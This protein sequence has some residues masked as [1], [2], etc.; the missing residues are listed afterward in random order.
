MQ[1]KK[2]KKTIYTSNEGTSNDRRGGWGSNKNEEQVEGWE[3]I[4]RAF[5]RAPSLRA[6]KNFCPEV[7]RPTGDLGPGS[8]HGTVDRT[9]QA[10]TGFQWGPWEAPCLKMFFALKSLG[11]EVFLRPTKPAC[12]I[13]SRRH[14]GAHPVLTTSSDGKEPHCVFMGG[15]ARW[16]PWSNC[17]WQS[18]NCFCIS[19]SSRLVSSVQSWG[20]NDKGSFLSI[21]RRQLAEES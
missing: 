11:R 12:S 14:S 4:H 7:K 18:L 10:R 2:K 17:S 8:G 1:K 21:K 16:T 19:K 6:G 20:M 5:T 13:F 3:L 15:K 9:G